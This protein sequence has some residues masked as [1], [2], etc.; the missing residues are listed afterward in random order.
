[1]SL[2]ATRIQNEI[3]GEFNRQFATRYSFDDREQAPQGQNKY[4]SNFILLD[5]HNKKYLLKVLLLDK[6]PQANRGQVQNEIDICKGV[7]SPYV[8]R[9]IDHAKTRKYVFLIFPFIEGQNLE[10]YAAAQGRISELEAKR[11][12]I[13]ML[14][15]IAD[16]HRSCNGNIV[17]QDLKP[18]NVMITSTGNIILLDF[19][20]ARYKQSPFKGN[21][22][23]NFAYSSREQI[24]ASRPNNLKIL[25]ITICDKADVFSAGLILYR[26]LEGRHPHHG[27][28]GK[29]PADAILE[30]KNI[31]PIS[32]SDISI[33]MKKI[34]SRMLEYE[35]LNR[36]NA[37]QAI[38]AFEQGNIQPPSLGKSK[39]FY[40]GASAVGRFMRFKDQHP[41]LF[42]GLVIEAS[43]MPKDPR[44][45]AEMR[46]NVKTLIIDPQTY[47]FQKPAAAGKKFRGVSY[48]TEHELV[49]N[50]AD[51]IARIAAKDASIKD[52]IK[53]VF[54]F[55]IENGAD[56]LIAPYFYI[57]EFN[58][59][60]WTIDQDLAILS[61]EIY[62][63]L[64]TDKPLIKG[65]AVS[66]EVLQSDD[67]R[68]RI[69]EY[70]QSLYDYAGFFVLLDSSHRETITNEGWLKSA[71]DF[72]THLL[73]TQ[74]FVIWSRADLFGLV[75]AISGLN[76]AT[77]EFQKQKKFNINEPIQK[78]G[79]R[80]K[81]FYLP[82]MFARIKYPEGFQALNAYEQQ[83]DL[84]CNHHCCTGIDFTRLIRREE[85][86]LALHSMVALRA[87]FDAYIDRDGAKK[88][89]DD[90]K[91]AKGHYDKIKNHQ[92]IL[93]RHA[94]NN[95]IK[96]DSSSFL[97]SW[98]NTLGIR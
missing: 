8:A 57:P 1:M 21:A 22:R 88:L 56:I 12:G 85:E 52:F 97:T 81:Y 70:L 11:I 10:Q 41:Q 38:A 95:D 61:V 49:Q 15:G 20:A 16:I 98:T 68:N 91:K 39:F 2:L 23:H 46:T 93:V 96:P 72:F 7:S 77:G 62:T 40:C 42:D 65:I 89:S 36:L 79:R 28:D 64:E 25:R 14:R 27:L 67:S 19:G 80:G 4:S 47:L 31:Y 60:Y 63:E 90:I 76:M 45:I 69:L 73:A 59:D 51:L 34:V 43:Q 32:R 82:A 3:K 87:Q 24:L 75:L 29:L 48:Y 6:I 71:R 53:K 58:D 83:D 74:K 66:E 5:P 84:I 13:E 50:R 86:D 9:L 18:E 26:L 54:Q 30:A 94:L 78:F 35:P 17:H 92:N 55:Q 33:E 37:Q 44:Q